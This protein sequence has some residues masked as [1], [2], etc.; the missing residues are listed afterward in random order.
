MTMQKLQK[1]AQK[2]VS[3]LLMVALVFGLGATALPKAA[4]ADDPVLVSILPA[5]LNLAFEGSHGVVAPPE[6][7]ISIPAHES[8]DVYYEIGGTVTGS[9]YI[10]NN[11]ANTSSGFVTVPA[12]AER[13]Q[14]PFS[15]IDDPDNEGEES[16][17]V[18]LVSVDNHGSTIPVEITP[19][20]GFDILRYTIVDNDT[21]LPSLSF[22]S[23]TTG[24]SEEA[25]RAPFKVL[26]SHINGDISHVMPGP[27]SFK[28]RV[29]SGT[30]DINDYG[31]VS[32]WTDITVPEGATFVDLPVVIQDDSI[33]EVKEET[34]KIQ[35][36]QPVNAQFVSSFESQTLYIYDNDTAVASFETA[37]EADLEADIIH[38]THVVLSKQVDREVRVTVSP[39]LSTATEGVDGDYEF[40]TTELVFA[41]LVVE[42]DDVYMQIHD[43]NDIEGNETAVLTLSN[44]QNVDLDLNPTHTFTIIDNETPIYA[45]LQPSS[46]SE[47]EGGSATVQFV[48]DSPALYDTTINYTVSSTANSSDFSFNGSASFSGSVVVPAGE[49]SAAA[50][51]A[52]NLDSA[53]EGD[54]LVEI[55]ISGVSSLDSRVQPG[56][57]ILYTNTIIDDDNLLTINL[58]SATFANIENLPGGFTVTLNRPSPVPVAFKWRTVPGTAT[59]L[60]T[61]IGDTTFSPDFISPTDW[62]TSTIPANQ[63]T[64][65]TTLG[66]V[67][68]NLFEG[69]ETFSIEIDTADPILEPGTILHQT[70]TIFANDIPTVQFVSN[71]ASGSEFAGTVQVPVSLS[72]P[73]PFATTLTFEADT[74]H[75]SAIWGDTSVSGND[76]QLVTRTVTIPAGETS[77]NVTL[78][79]ANDSTVEADELAIVYLSGVVGGVQGSNAT[80]TYTIV[81]D[82]SN[83]P[84]PTSGGGGGGGSSSGGSSA[85]PLPIASSAGFGT[86]THT[87]RVDS[88]TTIGGLNFANLVLNGGTATQMAIS[89]NAAFENTVTMPYNT[90]AIW[91]LPSGSGNKTIYVKFFNSAGVASAVV[92]ANTEATD[93]G[94]VVLGE[95]ISLLDELIARL[96]AGTTSDEV[97][98]LQIEL[99]KRGYFA[100]TFRPTRLYGA[101]TKAAV[102]KYLADQNAATMTLG[103]MLRT[104]KF[105]QRSA[106]VTRL[107]NELKRLGYFPANVAVTNYYGAVTKAAVAKY[108]ASK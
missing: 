20:P 83:T 2:I 71:T 87:V 86:E 61:T 77:A 14:L 70:Y 55:A 51:L 73:S 60:E 3:S 107:Q 11:N 28:W 7:I 92:T 48:L 6:I 13:V 72:N 4:K 54:E 45:N 35:I 43:D 46:A 5:G 75:S 67:D 88:V 50:L 59:N 53:V 44:P 102:A 100:K 64:L 36:S 17:M 84:P 32:D 108:Q 9:D 15:I 37:T 33:D 10:F 106:L 104:L 85:L 30:A 79:V 19:T 94:G 40:A 29:M 81:N 105:G 89:N 21:D 95:Q 12:G 74:I 34:A 96:R 8:F 38:T 80:H 90:A 49:T 42:S 25:T 66:V 31:A 57:A 98:Q 93:Q 91:K 1:K 62:T 76:L 101:M 52:T 47:L 23:L 16:L 24:R 82:D 99:Q 41:P 65:G 97:R 27:V 18:R 78:S 58:T 69:D 63:I 39:S 22:A 56:S 103:E 26:V 68:D